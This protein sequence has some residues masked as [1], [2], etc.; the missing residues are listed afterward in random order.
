[1]NKR[2]ATAARAQQQAVWRERARRQAESG[3]SIAAFC[4]G[5]GIS[6]AS[7]YMWRGRHRSR[8]VAVGEPAA[9]RMP[10]SFI[11]VGAMVGQQSAA[12]EVA[13]PAVSR[14]ELHLDLGGGMVL[15]LVRQ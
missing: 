8:A 2:G 3:Q 11:D 1:M 13:A 9:S 6:A 14:I 7:F 12:D 10:A 5:E 4:R 15:H